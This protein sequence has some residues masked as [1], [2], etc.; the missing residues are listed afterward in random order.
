MIAPEFRNCEAT[1]LEAP[2]KNF[3]SY[4]YGKKKQWLEDPQPKLE[5]LKDG[6]I[7]IDLWQGMECGQTQV[8]TYRELK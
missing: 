4:N 7:R 5:H 2:A 1:Q 6:L 3:I 8:N